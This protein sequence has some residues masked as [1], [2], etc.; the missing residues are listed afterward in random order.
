MRNI[1][2]WMWVCILISAIGLTIDPVFCEKHQKE[3]WCWIEAIQPKGGGG[4][5]DM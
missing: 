3:D 1:S 5:I 2:K 4:V